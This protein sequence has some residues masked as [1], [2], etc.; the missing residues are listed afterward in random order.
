VL[1]KGH[2]GRAQAKF[3]WSVFIDAAHQTSGLS[4]RD[5]ESTLDRITQSYARGFAPYVDNSIPGVN[6]HR[7]GRFI[8]GTV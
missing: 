1:G 5:V 6:Q 3:T 4:R 7:P 8:P 2:G